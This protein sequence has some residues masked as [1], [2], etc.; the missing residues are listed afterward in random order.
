VVGQFGPPVAQAGVSI[1][2]P[3]LALPVPQA[4]ATRSRRS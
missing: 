3:R 4:R 1:P 2:E